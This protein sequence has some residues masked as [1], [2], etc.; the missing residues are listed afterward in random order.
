MQTCTLRFPLAPYSND[1]LCI[2]LR[3]IRDISCILDLYGS[4]LLFK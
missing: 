1:D 4:A 3:I 2:P